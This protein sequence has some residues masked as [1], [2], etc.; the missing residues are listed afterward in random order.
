MLKWALIFAIISVVAAVFGFG[1]VSEAAG[2]IAKVIFFVFLALCIL[3]A[4]LAIFA[5]RRFR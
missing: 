3:F 1:G 2:D 4:A 5:V